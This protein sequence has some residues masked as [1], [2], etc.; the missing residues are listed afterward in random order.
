MSSNVIELP[1]ATL[2]DISHVLRSI[3]DEIDAGTYGDAS[4]A[5]LVLETGDNEIECFGAGGGADHYRGI[6]ILHK[7]LNKLCST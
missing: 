4:M 1:R 6:A 7:G 5:V 3:A 2:S